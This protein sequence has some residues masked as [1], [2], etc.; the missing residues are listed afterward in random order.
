MCYLYC[1]SSKIQHKA[2]RAHMLLYW[3]IVCL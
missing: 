3:D 1:E 2:H